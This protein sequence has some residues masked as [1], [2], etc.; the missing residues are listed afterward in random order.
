MW[1]YM[2]IYILFCTLL[3]FEKPGGNYDYPDMAK[4][5]GAY[6]LDYGPCSDNQKIPYLGNGT[7]CKPCNKMSL[8]LYVYILF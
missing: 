7:W 6:P 1:I 2:L 3:Q 4:E 8:S 5:A